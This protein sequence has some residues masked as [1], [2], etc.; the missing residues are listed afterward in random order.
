MPAMAQERIDLRT[1]PEIKELTA[2][3]ASTAGLTVS[4]FPR[5]ATQERA[6]Q[7]LAEAE[8][9]GVITLVMAALRRENLPAPYAA[10]F[11]N[12]PLPVARL[13]RLAV[14]LPHQRQGL[15]GTAGGGRLAALRAAVRRDRDAGPHRGCEG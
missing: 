2:R 10:R 5:G 6:R 1:S 15:G 9:H 13:A 12:F 14:A 4:A 11:P 7:V 8:I 3:A